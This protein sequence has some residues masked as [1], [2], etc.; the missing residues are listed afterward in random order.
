MKNKYM[1]ESNLSRESAFRL[2]SRSIIISSMIIAGTFIYINER[3]SVATDKVGNSEI[4]KAELI[5]DAVIPAKD[6]ILPVEWGD[7]GVRLTELGVIDKEKFSALYER[8]GGITDREWDL[9]NNPNNDSIA[10]NSLN[11]GFLLN[12]FWAL[13]LATKNEIL[14]SGPMVDPQYG[15]AENFASTGGWTLARGNVMDHYSMHRLI[16]LTADEQGMVEEMSKH[17][18]RPCCNNPTHF[19]DCN[20]G[21]AMLGLLELM[22]S[23]G[24]SEDEM[25][26]IALRVNSYWFPDAYT[27]IATYLDSKGIAWKDADPRAI[28]DSGYSSGSGYRNIVSQVS[29][30]TQK[31]GSGCGV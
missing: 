29:S 18:F 4:S 25:Y 14:D 16:S 27:T 13:G 22:A 12:L 24:L 19:P 8:R 17:I 1:Q 15:G 23:Q 31:S 26:K 9:I 3:N 28:L 10:M 11:S 30:P 6:F 20:H 2:F 7:L 5:E 21:M